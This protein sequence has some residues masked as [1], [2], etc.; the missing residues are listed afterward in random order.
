M[1]KTIGN[2]IV[3]AT[4]TLIPCA[5]VAMPLAA[6]AQDQNQD[7]APT[8]VIVSATKAPVL[9]KLDKTVYDTAN[10]P[11]A[12]NGT[13][14]DVLQST[15]ELSVSPDGK[16]SV[17]GNSQVTVLIDGKPMAITSGS[18]DETAVALQTMSGADIASVEVITNPSAAYNANGGSIVNIVLKRNRKPGAHAQLQASASDHG[19]WNAGA[20]ADMT[21]DKLSLH[22]NLGYRHDGNVKIRESVVEWTNPL[23]GHTSQTTQSSEVF[24]HRVVESGALGA[25]YA[26]SDTDSLGL[27][28]RYNRRRSRPVYDVLNEVRDEFHNDSAA[29]VYHRISDGPNEQ[30]DKSLALNYS[31]QA[32]GTVLKVTAQHSQTIGLIDKSYRDIFL[33]PMLPTDYSRGVTRPARHL[34][35]ATLDWSGLSKAFGQLGMGLDFQHKADDMYNYQA[36]VDPV[37]GVE[38]ADPNTSNAYGVKTTLSAAYLTDKMKYGKWEVLLGG[39]VERMGLQVNP[40][41]DSARTKHWQ[42]F[43]PSLHLRFELS[44]K[45]DLTLSYRSSLQMPDPRDLN[46]FTTYIDAQNLGRGNPNLEPQRLTSWEIGTNVEVASLS[47]S[48]S[49]FYRTSSNTVTDARS[50]NDTVLITSK[51][52]GGRARSTGITSSLDWTFNPQLKLGIDGGVYQVLLRTPD[53]SGPVRQDGIAGYLNARA[54][55]SAGG[56]IVSLDAHLQSSAIAPLGRSGSTSNVN[57][58]WKHQVDKTL[59]LTVNLNDIFDGSNRHYRTYAETFR[60][61]GFDHILGRRFYIGFSKKL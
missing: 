7:S 23:E 50:F 53:L 32:N 47:A 55:Y 8:T 6:H 15:P 43:N 51:E 4:L 52:N 39:R 3:R 21:R 48:V 36:S 44:N 59:S 61:S 35:Q 27:Q 45:T 12:V 54:A 10:M 46:P 57:L 31:H 1:H 25:D 40:A 58:S 9:R 34:N 19:L 56:E 60:Q 18:S 37:T 22:G 24:V 5:Y 41:H 26:L 16:L 14:Q 17:K 49:A 20:S 30:S 33:A 28:A 38:L 11:R 13:A 2:T 29:T 42:A